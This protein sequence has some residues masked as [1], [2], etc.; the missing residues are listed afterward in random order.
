MF[1]A[2]RRFSDRVANYVRH[3]PSYPPAVIRC[4]EEQAG[5]SSA[6]IVADLGSGTGIFTALLLPRAM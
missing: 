5:M 3:R 1:N 2:T 6:S 4:L